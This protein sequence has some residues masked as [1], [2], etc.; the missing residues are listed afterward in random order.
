MSARR[1]QWLDGVKLQSRLGLMG[2]DEATPRDGAG[3]KSPLQECSWRSWL[4]K[5]CAVPTSSRSVAVQRLGK[6]LS[7]V[8]ALCEVLG[9][10]KVATLLMQ[11][12]LSAQ[13]VEI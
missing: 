13:V 3:Y 2:A 1:V 8:T 9:R 5:R 4:V 6:L 7:A 11:N 12:K 10:W